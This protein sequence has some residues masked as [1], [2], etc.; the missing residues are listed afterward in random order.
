MGATSFWPPIDPRKGASP[1]LNTP[2]SLATNQYPLALAV[3]TM[4]VIGELRC[5]PPSDP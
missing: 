4:P 2:P 1:K 5:W 3:A